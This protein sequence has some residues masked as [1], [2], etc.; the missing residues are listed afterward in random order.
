MS[1]VPGVTP[2]ADTSARPRWFLVSHVGL[3]VKVEGTLVSWPE[4]SDVLALGLDPGAAQYLGRHDDEDC[5]ALH[6]EDAPLPAP[7]GAQ[8]LR[9]LYPALGDELF[10]VAGRA[11]Q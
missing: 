6:V 8:G 4:L 2:P 11:V 5:F 9:G 3:V 10:P 7:W 1:F